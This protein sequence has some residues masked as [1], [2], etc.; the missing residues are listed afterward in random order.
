MIVLWLLSSG[1]MNESTCVKESRCVGVLVGGQR[2]GSRV[3]A[4]SLSL[5]VGGGWA[6]ESGWSRRP[7]MCGPCVGAK[8]KQY[9]AS[10]QM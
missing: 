5:S 8:R 9:Q 2:R 6:H 7:G 4:G 10:L 1:S 3:G